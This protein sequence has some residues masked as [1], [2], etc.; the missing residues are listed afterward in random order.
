MRIGIDV[1]CFADGRRTGVEEYALGFLESLFEM[2]ERNEYVLFFNSFKNKKI[3]FSWIEKYPHV[4]LKRFSYPN[5][6]LNLFFWYLQW[7]KIDRM[8]GGT[9]IFFMPNINFGA[10]SRKTKLVLTVHDLSYERYAQTFSWKRR[11]WH[12]FVNPKKICRRAD[13]IVAISRSTAFDLMELFGVREEKIRVIHN[14][15]PEKF[16][17]LDRNNENLIRVKEK[18]SLPYKFILYLGTIEPRKNIAAII[19]AYNRLQKNAFREGDEEMQK[20]KLV[21]A[22]SDGWL[23]E[24]IFE[25]AKQSKHKNSIIFAKF[26]KEKDKEYVLN[27]ASLFI[28]PSFFEGFGFPPLEAMACGVPTIASNNSSLPEVV[29]DGGIMIDAD[30][31]D[32]ICAA[33]KEIL[34]NRK[35]RE[36]LI[37]KGLLQS[38]KFTWK[39]AAGE[40]LKMIYKM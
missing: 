32:E 34:K 21:I 4:T 25:E 6:I 22:G 36:E 5:K 7:P 33:A 20:Y 9:D 40:F 2:D 12:F 26:I 27:L 17:A 31:P 29:G 16:R 37:S 8:V 1:R 28:Y 15:L 18:Y 39:K 24:G 38:E 10:F 30:K 35:F 19:R 14:G 3:D 11:A 23:S 13:R